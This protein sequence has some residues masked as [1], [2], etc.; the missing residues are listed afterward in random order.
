K[1]DFSR[2]WEECRRMGVDPGAFPSSRD[3]ERFVRD[4]MGV[5]LDADHMREIRY[6]KAVADLAIDLT[7]DGRL[8]EAAALKSLPYGIGFARERER[9]IAESEEPVP[10]DEPD[11]RIGEEELNVRLAL[12]A[13]NYLDH[14]ARA[15]AW[16]R[17][18]EEPWFAA[19]HVA[20][21]RVGVFAE[22]P[23]RW[24]HPVPP[25]EALAAGEAAVFIEG[26]LSLETLRALEERLRPADPPGD[27]YTR[28][29]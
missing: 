13:R 3:W 15:A 22:P 21:G 29:N 19:R 16:R 9:L 24:W 25:E 4:S 6:Q 14:A 27:R 20:D 17:G 26:D 18:T 23:G 1:A 8:R 28:E 2:F 7:F 12:L 5:R 10:E 11:T